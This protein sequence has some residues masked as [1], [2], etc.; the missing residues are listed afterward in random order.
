TYD[1][2][3][4]YL[5]ANAKDA[6]Y[7]ISRAIRT[8]KLREELRN[9]RDNNKKKTRKDKRNTLPEKLTEPTSKDMHDREL[10]FVEGDSAAGSAKTGRDRKTQGVLALRGKVLNTETASEQRILGN[11]EIQTIIQA[12][13]VEM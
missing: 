3:M 12:L 9:L 6:E 1:N 7:L 8:Q 2:I 4:Q 10:F 5:H 13:G 11:A